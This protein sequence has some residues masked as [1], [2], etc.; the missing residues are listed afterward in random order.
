L[1]GGHGTPAHYLHGGAFI[2]NILNGSRENID[3][4]HKLLRGTVGSLQQLVGYPQ[5]IRGGIILRKDDVLTT[6]SEDC[7]HLIFVNITAAR[8]FA[9][10]PG[11]FDN[12]GS[13]VGQQ[14]R[15]LSI[16]EFIL[17]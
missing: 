12:H 3:L 14:S 2:I 4:L 15:R 11:P 9:C 1:I 17:S 13:V 6:P 16:P 8:D 10:S 5:S 7:Y